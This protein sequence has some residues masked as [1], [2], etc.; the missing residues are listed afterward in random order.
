MKKSLGLFIVALFF[1][2]P[3]SAA[4]NN[5]VLGKW[6]TKEGKSHVVISSCDAGLCGKVVW[7]KR[8]NY[9]ADDSKG[10]A[11]KPKVDRENPNP[12][13]RK[14]STIGI[15]VLNGFKTRSGNVW[16]DGT[17]YDPESGKTY[18]AKLTLVDSRT[19]KVRGFIGFSWIGRTS[20]WTR[21]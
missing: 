8:P 17:A 2:T 1:V 20:I 14:R 7:L 4:E 18:K 3:V 16:E 9:P 6:V 12:A 19:L 13:L 15:Q 11:G 21:K 10:M 5:G